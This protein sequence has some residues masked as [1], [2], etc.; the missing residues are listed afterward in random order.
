MGAVVMEGGY[1]AR[2]HA[3]QRGLSSHDP[4][5]YPIRRSSID[6][7]GRRHEENVVE[8]LQVLQDVTWT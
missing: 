3:L 1:P 7:R 2:V 4:A 8:V 6:A 5:L